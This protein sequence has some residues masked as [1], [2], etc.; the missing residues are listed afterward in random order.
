MLSSK[1]AQLVGDLE[2]RRMLI[3]LWPLAAAQL[4]AVHAQTPVAQSPAASIRFADITLQ[5]ELD[6]QHVSGAMDRMGYLPGLMASGM[7]LLN[8]DNDGLCDA[9]MLNGHRLPVADANDQPVNQLFRNQGSAR[10][11]DVSQR[12]RSDIAAFALGVA[13]ADYDNDGF[14]DLAISNLGSVTLL[15]NNGDGTF[16]DMTLQAG[17]DDAG[18]VFGAGLAFLDMEGDGD[19]DLYVADYVDFKFDGYDA[20]LR[21]TYPYPPGPDHFAH[22]ADHLF[23]NCGDGRFVDDSQRAGIADVRSPSMGVVCGDFDGDGDTDIFVCSDAKPNLLWINDGNGVFTEQAE[24]F[25][26]AYNAN[27]NPIGSMGAEAADFDSDG[28]ED[29]FITSYS[30][31]MPILFRNLGAVGFV[32]QTHASRSGRDVIPHANWGALLADFDNDG[33][34]DLMIANGHLFTWVNEVE[35]LTEFKVRNSLLAND[36]R[37]R[38][39][40]VSGSAGDGLAVVES[41]RGMA[42]DDLDN[43]GDLDVVILNSESRATVLRNDTLNDNHWIAI[44]LVGETANRDGVGATVSVESD[45]Q[46][47]VAEVRSGRGYQSAYGLRLHFGLGAQASAVQ[48][49][50]NWLGETT[51]YRDLQIDREHVLRQGDGG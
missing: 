18:I 40:N 23:E 25:G 16:H 37:G 15:R 20:L 2:F 1:C 8:F 13:V 9:Y 30:T 35:Q 4:P 31:Q 33:D 19:L 7:S 36:G 17:L 45:G 11:K 47:Q 28:F 51:A 43:D 29:L 21:K 48:V 22:R 26:A 14:Q 41:S 44:R 46:V 3:L 5:S 6:F 24:L 50:V 39:T 10:F 27:G 38:F 12:S 34:R 42:C 32:D 49:R